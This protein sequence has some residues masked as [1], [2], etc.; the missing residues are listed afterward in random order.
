MDEGVPAGKQG[1]A[2]C[3]GQVAY[4]RNDRMVRRHEYETTGLDL[5]NALATQVRGGVAREL[6]RQSKACVI[7]TDW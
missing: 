1:Q 7:F 6:R 4:R 3:A 2:T 5:V